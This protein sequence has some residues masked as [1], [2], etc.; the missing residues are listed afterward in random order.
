MLY[1][2]LSLPA[3]ADDGS[4]SAS[5]FSF[6]PWSGASLAVTDDGTA[7]A[8]SFAT[9]LPGSSRNTLRLEGAV[10]TS[11]FGAAETGGEYTLGLALGWTNSHDI[12]EAA[13]LDLLGRLDVPL[14]DAAEVYQALRT[15]LE[16]PG[17]VDA[18][19]LAAWLQAKLPEDLDALAGELDGAAAAIVK[20]AKRWVEEV[21]ATRDWQGSG[22]QSGALARRDLLVKLF[23]DDA[24][25]AKGLCG[26]K[27]LMGDS[28]PVDPACPI[29]SVLNAIEGSTATEVAAV[30]EGEESATLVAIPGLQEA[31]EAYVER[32]VPTLSTAPST[33]SG[34][35]VALMVSP[36]DDIALGELRRVQ[37]SVWLDGGATFTRFRAL[38]EAGSADSVEFAD[39][40]MELGLEHLGFTPGGFAWRAALHYLG[41]VEHGLV[42][43]CAGEESCEEP[44]VPTLDGAASRT[45]DLAIEAGIGW[46]GRARIRLPDVGGVTN[47]TEEVRYY[48]MVEL[49]GRLVDL[50]PEPEGDPPNWEASLV[51]GVR[52]VAA[53][54]GFG[55][56]GTLQ[57]D[58]RVRAFVP[59][60][61]INGELPSFGSRAADAGEVAEDEEPEADGGAGVDAQP[62]DPEAEEPLGGDG[63]VPGVETPPLGG[64]G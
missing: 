61:F 56:G 46:I 53:G 51:A 49:Q 5:E 19:E 12:A 23:A 31:V 3:L 52:P 37:L 24:A 2:L 32:Y 13:Y 29:A 41:T 42:D 40:T 35:A 27:A 48:P 1:L 4:A 62:A 58:D 34:S 15:E 21:E 17:E 7:A 26:S 38:P 25:G 28:L 63:P 54:A 6:A 64:G 45:H 33:A 43:A 57:G 44:E 9:G 11:L 55:L 36:A 47:A 50:V 39:G 20:Q 60:L 59:T 30:F 8:V 22:A 10:P 16:I 14:E 18:D